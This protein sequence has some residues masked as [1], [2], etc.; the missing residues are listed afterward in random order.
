M[1]KLRPARVA[2]VPLLLS[3]ALFSSPLWFVV[4]VAYAASVSDV[5]SMLKTNASGA[6]LAAEA[7]VKAEPKNGEAWIALAQ[8]RVYAKQYEKAIDAGEKA[9][10]LSPKNAQAH[11]WLGNALGSRIGQVGMLG[12]MSIAPKL[13]DAFEQ[14]VKLDPSLS[15]AR[16]SLI[17]FYLQAPSVAGGSVDK[18][19]AQAAAMAKYDRATSLGAQARIAMHEKNWAQAVKYGEAAMT[20]KPDDAKMRQQLI[21][22]YQET[23]RWSDAYAA[24]KKWIAQSPNSNNAYYQLGR[25]AA[26][27]GQYLPEGETALRTYL[28]MPRDAE[29]PQP[30]NAHYRLGQVLAKVGRKDEARAA[31]QAALKLDPKMREAKDALAAL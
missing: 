4:G 25:L 20:L 11:Y 1:S 13:H 21:V 14:A 5:Q 28:K 31:F 29:D 22:L 7:L 15:D 2:L 23:K 3:C 12:K 19:K 27:S 6:L 24:V 26:E 10:G 8:A 16:N 9:V 18:A 30:K 17:Q